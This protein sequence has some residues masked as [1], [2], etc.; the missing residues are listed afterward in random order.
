MEALAVLELKGIP[1]AALLI[2]ADPFNSVQ[3]R[4]R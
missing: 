2:D 1:H 4:D 3:Y